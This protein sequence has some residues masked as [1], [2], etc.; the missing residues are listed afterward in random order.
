M[1]FDILIQHA[2]VAKSVDARDLKSLE[3][4]TH[5]GSIPVPGTTYILIRSEYTMDQ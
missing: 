1:V 2:R 3:Y 5:T 4:C